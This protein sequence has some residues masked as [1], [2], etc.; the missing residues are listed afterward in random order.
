MIEASMTPFGI[1]RKKE[2]KEQ[3]E[4]K[5]Q[6]PKKETEPRK[7]AQ[8]SL[9]EELCGK[10]QELYEVLSRTIILNPKTA[11]E[12]GADAYVEKAQT[13]EKG[14][15]YVQARIAYQMAG[16]ISLYEGRLQQ[17]QRLFK[18]AAEVDP[19]YSSRTAFE[20]FS[21]KE[22]AERAMAVAKE[23]YTKTGKLAEAEQA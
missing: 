22:N 6:G 21:R 17:V 23:F 2:K 19:E 1:F 18:K 3:A 20:F 10:D 5:E 9:L 12:E 16:E 11:I 13:H 7:P 4:A 8:K 14:G 15:N